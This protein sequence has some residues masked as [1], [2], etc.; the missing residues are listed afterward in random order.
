MA[1]TAQIPTAAHTSHTGLHTGTCY[2]TTYFT[3][4]LIRE[5]E[6]SL[7][8]VQIIYLREKI[9]ALLICHT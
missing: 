8:N 3:Y 9:T 4:C 2:T 5:T 7:Q 1:D 6:N